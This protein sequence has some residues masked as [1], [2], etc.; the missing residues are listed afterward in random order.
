VGHPRLF[1]TAGG[2][3]E[4]SEGSLCQSGF[5]TAPQQP[6]RTM[7]GRPSKDPVR[8][9]AW[10]F[11]AAHLHLFERLFP[12]G[13]RILDSKYSLA[14]LYYHDTMPHVCATT[15]SQPRLRLCFLC[16][17][18][19]LCVESLFRK[20]QPFTPFCISSRQARQAE[21]A[22]S[23]LRSFALSQ[24]RT[25]LLSYP[26]ALFRKNTREGVPLLV[27]RGLKN[28]NQESG[29]IRSKPRT[30]NTSKHAH[31]FQRT[32][33]EITALRAMAEPMLAKQCVSKPSVMNTCGTTAREAMQNEHLQ[34]K[35]GGGTLAIKK[36]R[37]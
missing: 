14:F 4:R 3:P 8:I 32:N 12:Q 28:E 15:R 19:D 31:K 26:C 13:I 33:I 5:S 1:S 10:G 16:A 25:S 7:S 6:L 36:A 34:K 24:N 27:P 11:C 29:I 9:E 17:L 35:G 21:L 18:C 22:F 37:V 20:I 2:H 30:I 23:L